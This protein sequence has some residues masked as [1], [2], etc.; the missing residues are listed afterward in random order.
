MLVYTGF[1]FYYFVNRLNPNI[2]KTSLIRD[3]AEDLPFNP[4]EMGFDFAFGL[5][6]PLDPS[7]GFFTVRQ[8]NQTVVNNERVKGQTDLAF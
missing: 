6:K 1:R 8:R 7:I 4:V 3:A 5:Q 2:A